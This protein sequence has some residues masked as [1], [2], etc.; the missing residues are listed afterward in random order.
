[1]PE[2]SDDVEEGRP[3]PPRKGRPIGPSRLTPEVHQE[4]VAYVRAGAFAHVAAR[5]AGISPRTFYD[6]LERREGRHPT[7]SSTPKLEVFAREV[8]QAH[9]FAR[10]KAEVEVFRKN[11]AHWLRY[12][13]RTDDDGDG[14]S[15]PP[16]ESDEGRAVQQQ[17]T[18]IVM[19]L[20]RSE[21]EA[22]WEPCDD[23]DC[24][25]AHE[26]RNDATHGRCRQ[27]RTR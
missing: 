7:R 23:I 2:P 24:L 11:P 18:D 12:A 1:M 4:I 5:A 13:A 21:A 9:A 15:D 27:H 16:A 6:W 20:A 19:R 25:R 10:I 14:W 3:D 17:V 8:G 26:R 22:T